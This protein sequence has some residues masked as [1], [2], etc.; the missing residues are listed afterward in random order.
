MSTAISS[1]VL[2]V[3]QAFFVAFDAA[4]E[5]KP[6]E[7]SKSEMDTLKS[8]LKVIVYALSLV[9]VLLIGLLLFHIYISRRYVAYHAQ[10]QDY[11]RISQAQTGD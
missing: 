1:I 4:L 7:N 10:R 2:F 8:M 11:K 3:I 9:A 5:D 6:K